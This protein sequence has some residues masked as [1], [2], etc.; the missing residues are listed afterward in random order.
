M[1]VVSGDWHGDWKNVIKEIKRLDLRNCTLFQV[2]D[3]GMGFTTKKKDLKALD[4]LNTTLKVR[5][6]QLYAIRG[7]HDNPAYFDGSISTSN[8]KLLPD[9]STIDVNGI[10]V[11][12]VGGAIS[13][14]RK[15]N[16]GH[17]D[18]RGKP[19]KGRKE[20]V[21][22]W[23][24]ENFVLKP[25]ILNEIKGIDIVIT[26]SAPDFC[27]PRT[28]HGL[29]GWAK[30]DPGLIEE[31][32]KERNDLSKMYDILKANG[33]SLK[34]WLYGHFHYYHKEQFDDT[35]FILIDINHFYDVRI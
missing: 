33:C 19:W 8:I 15:P 25:E 11:L 31:C 1:I 23:S 35:N 26:H 14:D 16:P 7:N 13:V 5:S 32:A 20:G 34:Y 10:K 18:F 28:K 12:L 9:Y 6:I 30:H 24:N 22:Y 3:F 4:Y 27:E 17:T 29:S 21:N 2:G